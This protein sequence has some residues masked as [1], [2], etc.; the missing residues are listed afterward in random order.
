M[1]FVEEDPLLRE[2]SGI[3]RKAVNP[4][5]DRFVGLMVPATSPRNQT[6]LICGT[7]RRDKKCGPCDWNFDGKYEFRL[8]D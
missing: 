6:R 5:L 1:T 4:N 3:G 2:K 8:G 7:N